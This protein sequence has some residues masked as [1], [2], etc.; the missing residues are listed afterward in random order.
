MFSEYHRSRF[1]NQNPVV[2]ELVAVEEM[3]CQ[4]ATEGTAADDHDV[5]RPGIRPTGRA[6][7]GLIEAVAN[8]SPEHV[9][10]EVRV[11]RA[12]TCGHGNLLG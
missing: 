5:K 6:A 10:A 1:K 9:L 7:H 12:G 3:L 11:L 4:S 2:A 8:I